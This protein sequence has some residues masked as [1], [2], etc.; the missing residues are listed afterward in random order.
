MVMV[1]RQ[2]ASFLALPFL[3]AVI[4]PRAIA[5]RNQV[6]F[7]MP[8]EVLAWTTALAGVLFL[9]LGVALFSASLFFFWTKGRGTLAPWD[10]PRRF[11]VEGPYRFVR[12]PMI[13]GVL[14]V[15]LGEA[16]VL[17]SWPHAAWAA[18]FFAINAVYIPL[19]EEPGLA[20]RFGEPYARYTRAVRRFLPRRR[21]WMLDY[22]SG[23]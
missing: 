15:L 18:I 9:A 1:I 3:V 6:T 10:P 20:S 17:R 22:P 14:F 5:R 7:T 13:S 23:V 8:H 16:C 4:V 21:P 11:V 19:F 2:L 12:N